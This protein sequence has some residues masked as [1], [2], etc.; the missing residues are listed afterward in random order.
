MSDITIHILGILFTVLAGTVGGV[1]GWKL[2]D[3]RQNA[4]LKK[5]N[6]KDQNIQIK[7]S[8]VRGGK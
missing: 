7:H 4:K 3:W 5:F 6:A 2:F 1:L 8:S